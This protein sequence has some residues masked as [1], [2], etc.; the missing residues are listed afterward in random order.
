[1]AKLS[2]S[3]RALFDAKT[4]ATVSTIQPDGS[5][6]L[7]VVWVKVDGDDVVFSTKEGRRKHLNLARDPRITLLAMPEG[8]P[9]AYTEIRGTAT[10]VTEGGDALI[11]ELSHKYTGAPYAGDQ[12]GDVRLVVR[13]SADRIVEHG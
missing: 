9:Y 8:N 2:D 11:D 1:M 13:V 3:A 5:V 7:S 6:Q 4:F 12:P 10:M